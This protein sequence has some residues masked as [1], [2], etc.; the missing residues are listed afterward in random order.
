MKIAADVTCEHSSTDS[1]AAG[2]GLRRDH[3]GSGHAEIMRRSSRLQQHE[4]QQ[5]RDD[6]LTPVHQRGG[7]LDEVGPA[8]LKVEGGSEAKNAEAVMLM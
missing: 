4:Q 2:G 8:P 7:R 3:R 5:V 1:R 6:L